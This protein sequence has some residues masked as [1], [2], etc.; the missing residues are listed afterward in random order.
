[1]CRRAENPDSYW[2]F[3]SSLSLP[4]LPVPL[5]LSPSLAR[6]LSHFAVNSS[7][8]PLCSPPSLSLRLH[9][10]SQF[11]LRPQD[12]SITRRRANTS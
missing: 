3:K 11:L 8:F 6:S 2:E 1:M 12:R 10:F 5:S 7:S 4:L 9:V